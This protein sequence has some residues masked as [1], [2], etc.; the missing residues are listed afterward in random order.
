MAENTVAIGALVISVAT[1]VVNIVIK[2]W[3]EYMKLEWDKQVLAADLDYE[4]GEIQKHATCLAHNKQ[5]FRDSPKTT[6]EETLCTLLDQDSPRPAELDYA[7]MFLQRSEDTEEVQEMDEAKQQVARFVNKVYGYYEAH[8]LLRGTRYTWLRKWMGLPTGDFFDRKWVGRGKRH[9]LLV[10]P[11]D[12]ANWYK[13]GETRD[14]CVPMHEARPPRYWLLQQKAGKVLGE[15]H[16]EVK[17][18]IE[19]RNDR[20]RLALG[21]KL[22][23]S[24]HETIPPPK[25]A[26]PASGL[27]EVV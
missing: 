7:D 3:F 10:E 17:T 15:G 18:Q 8:M 12:V 20:Y 24:T 4:Y 16:V 21:L 9:C 19:S 1:F 22:G 26:A 14:Y 23:R 25:N 13:I 2:S 6:T 11:L 5:Y 27:H